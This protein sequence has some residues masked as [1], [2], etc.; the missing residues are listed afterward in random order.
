[1]AE[2]LVTFRETLEA[3][4]IVGILF[5]Y[6]VKSDRLELAP[7]LWSGVVAAV[8]G[9]LIAAL[10]FQALAGG[11]SG[12][13]EKIFEGIIM[14][15]AAGV[16]STMIVWMARNSNI[17]S[18]LEDK[19]R[20]ALASDSRA[21]L[22][23]FLLA[24]VAVFREGVETV[25]FLYGVLSNQGG[26]SFAASL[27]GGLTAVAI[28]YAIFVQG[29]RVPL[30]TFFNVS[31]VLLI[32]FAAGLIAH[33]IHEFHEAALLPYGE[34]IWDVNP[35]PRPDGTYP[36]FHDKGTVGALAKGLFGWNGDPSMPEVLAWLLSV[37]GIGLLWR[38][39]TLQ[40]SLAG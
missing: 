23:L 8:V 9:S 3:A 31:S 29:K 11:F 28:G 39:A 17:S 22:G 24:F 7:R 32:L 5:T 10:L 2:F 6:L 40:G 15:L 38:R 30:K 36:L 21:G 1:M 13:G 33:G 26:L 14:I 20:S 27:A 34:P 16:L 4:L 12:R 19:A 35:A 37:T 25:L 18:D